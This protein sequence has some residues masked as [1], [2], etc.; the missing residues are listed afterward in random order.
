MQHKVILVLLALV[1]AFFLTSSNTS[2]VYICTGNY[3]K[4][5]HY[6][7][8]CRGLSNCKAAIKGVSLEEARN[9]NRT[10]CGWED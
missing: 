10:L 8:T 7:N 2:K 5:Y 1:F 3:S 4:K 9:K 6:S